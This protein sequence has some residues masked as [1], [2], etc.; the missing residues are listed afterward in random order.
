MSV[1]RGLLMFPGCYLCRA[2]VPDRRVWLSVDPPTDF[3]VPRRLI[4]EP[5]FFAERVTD[6]PARV[7]SGRT[8]C[9][10]P[11]VTLDCREGA[12]L[13]DSAGAGVRGGG[14]SSPRASPW[15]A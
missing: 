10:G 12:A 8:A 2:L 3:L 7:A 1:D 15:V 4:V 14:G 6:L 13:F 11:S 9:L 5:E